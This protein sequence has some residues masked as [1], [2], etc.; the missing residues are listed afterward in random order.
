MFFNIFLKYFSHV[1]FFWNQKKFFEVFW[2]NFGVIFWD[3]FGSFFGSILALFF[4]SILAHFWRHFLGQF[5]LIFWISFWANLWS[6]FASNLSQFSTSDPFE[7]FYLRMM[8]KT[9]LVQIKKRAIRI[10]LS[11]HDEQ[12]RFRNCRALTIKIPHHNVK[13]RIDAV[14]TSVY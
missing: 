9:F 7:L 8:N 13:K 11:S 6:I 3:I 4:G 1:Y 12:N 5:W 14:L 2:I 10:I